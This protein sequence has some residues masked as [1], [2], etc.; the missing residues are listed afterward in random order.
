MAQQR[1][2]W[3][4]STGF[5]LAAIGS[6]VGLGNMWRFSYLTAEHGGAV[7]VLL[8]IVLLLLIGLPIMLAEFAV[9][10]STGQSSVQALARLGGNRWRPVGYLFVTSGFLILAYYAVIAGWVV[11]YTWVGITAGFT[12]DAG[13]RFG[14]VAAGWDAVMLQVAF[15]ALTVLVVAGGIRGGI[16]KASLYLMPLL[17]LIVGGLALYAATL[18]GAGEGYREYLVPDFDALF[19]MEVFTAAA[20]QAFFSLSLGMGALLTYASYLSREDNL[21]RE[22]L[23]IAGADF[24]VAFVAGLMIF[25]IVFALGLSAAVGESTVGTLFI[26]LPG[27]FAEMGGAGRV[28]GILFFVALL[29]GALTSAI[30]LLEVVVAASIDGLGWTRGK[31]ALIGGAAITLIGIPTALSTDWLGIYDTITGQVFLVVGALAIS[32]FVGWRMDAAVQEVERGA[33]GIRWVPFW[34]T[35]LRFVIPVILLFILFRSV[36]A[37]IAEVRGALAAQPQEVEDTL[38]EAPAFEGGAPV[39]EPQAE[40]PGG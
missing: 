8:Y 36:P 39:T 9:G 19:N 33:G 4:S 34:R 22:S 20:S 21:P 35:W 1:E 38:Q 40:R 3:A 17:F 18:D 16:E 27:A 24:A 6:A 14:E 25:P 37:A 12:G 26:S 30:S 5:V 13:A 28:I 15:M 23:V 31:A 11:R 32:L 10:R 29:V 7:F 2:Q